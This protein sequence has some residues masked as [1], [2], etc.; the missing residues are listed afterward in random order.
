MGDWYLGKMSK[1]GTLSE[2]QARNRKLRKDKKMKDN[3]SELHVSMRHPPQR[4]WGIE[5]GWNIF[6]LVEIQ[7]LASAGCEAGNAGVLK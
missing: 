6:S 4:S 1:R 7:F 2:E 5:F 3:K